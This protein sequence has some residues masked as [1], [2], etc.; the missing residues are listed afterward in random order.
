LLGLD[1]QP[2]AQLVGRVLQAALVDEHA[3]ALVVEVGGLLHGAGEPP[4]VPASSSGGRTIIA[5]PD[6]DADAAPA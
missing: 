3:H 1:R 4:I 5:L 6:G 2:G